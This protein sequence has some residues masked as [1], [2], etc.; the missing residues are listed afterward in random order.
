MYGDGD[1]SDSRKTLYYLGGALT[2]LGPII[3]LC[4]MFSSASSFGSSMPSMP[5]MPMQ[6]PSFGS[7]SMPSSFVVCLIGIVVGVIGGFMRTV[8]ARGVAGSGIILDP[9]QARRDL[10]PY[11]RMVGGMAADAVEEFTAESPRLGSP[12]ARPVIKVRCLSCNAL[13]D[14]SAAYCSSCGH[15][16]ANPSGRRG[17]GG[18]D[19]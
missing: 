7:S 13:N 11:S 2:V 17:S 6:G 19:H 8:G 14:D 1:I 16:L 15:P 9:Q 5:S 3:F 4:G 10:K 12:V 18:Q